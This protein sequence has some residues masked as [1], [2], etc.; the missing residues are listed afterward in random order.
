LRVFRALQGETFLSETKPFENPLIPNK[1]LRQLFVAMVEMRALD[2]HVARVQ[3]GVKARRRMV[4]TRGEEACRVS[5]GIEL[6]AG[7]LVSDATVGVAMG[8]VAG[9]GVGPLLRQV[10][11]GGSSVNAAAGRQLAWIEDVGDRL[12]MAMGAALAFKTLKR[13]N[14]VEAFV[15]AGEVSNGTW[16]RVLALASKLELP[17]I[18]VVLPEGSRKK[19]KRKVAGDLSALARSCGVP[20]I[21]VDAGDAV[22]LYRVAQ[23]S[24]GRMRGG[25][26]PVLVECVAFAAKGTRG[27]VDPLVQ[28]RGFLLGRRVCSEAWLDRA[29]EALTRQ[30]AAATGRR[31]TTKVGGEV[32]TPFRRMASKLEE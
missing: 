22:A 15:R 28:M 23:E 2:E 7:D 30:I 29:G 25:D 21:P 17:I 11:A 14:V 13:A 24:L 19:T 32:T 12:R 9:V 6:V 31:T 8:L 26:G 10:A 20:G 27:V 5:M 3:R 1:K 16:R 4:S 18:F